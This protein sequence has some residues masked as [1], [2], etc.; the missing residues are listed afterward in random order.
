MSTPFDT[1]VS[2]VPM[3]TDRQLAYIDSLVEQYNDL[4]GK[5][6]PTPDYSHMT[7]SE[8]SAVIDALKF[9]VEEARRDHYAAKTAE[10]KVQLDVEL[11]A[12]MYLVT[13][14]GPS[15]LVFKVY[16]AVH[17]SGR[18]LAKELV[19]T[20]SDSAVFEYRGLASRFVKADD[21]MSLD[22]AK[23][24]GA[25]YGVCVRCAATLTDEESIAAGIGPVCATKL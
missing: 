1:P 5:G 3:A 20:G 12:G 18:M 7:K 10:R 25:I 14:A 15:P 22:Q 8:A 9:R 17:G 23:A 24:Y 11:E 4:T 2:T 19:R 6:E 21:R 16:R 13:T